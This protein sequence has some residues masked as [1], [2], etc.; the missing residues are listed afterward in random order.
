MTDQFTVKTDISKDTWT[1]TFAEERLSPGLFPVAMGT[2]G[3]ETGEPIGGENVMGGGAMSETLEGPGAPETA[4]IFSAG[5]EIHPD[6]A[7]T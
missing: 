1:L 5:G 6:E 3:N 4:D 2:G 7:D